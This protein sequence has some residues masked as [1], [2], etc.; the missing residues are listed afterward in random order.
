[1]DLEKVKQFAIEQGYKTVEKLEQW[2]GYEVYE[3]IM[4]ENE[5]SD[6]GQPL[7]ILVKENT[8]RMSTE[9][10]AFQQMEDAE[11]HVSKTFG[12]LMNEF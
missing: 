2:N 4:D 7:L 3:P 10:E 9:E 12:E 6:I 5:I 1:M 11:K 8:I